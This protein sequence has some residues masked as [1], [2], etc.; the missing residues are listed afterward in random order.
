MSAPRKNTEVLVGLFLFVGFCFVG[1]MTVIFGT[2]GQ[3]MRHTYEVDVEFP[4][5]DGIIRNSDVMLSG[6]PIGRVAETPALVADSFH[7]RVKLKIR[8]DVK[9]PKAA[10]FTIASS[11]LLGDKYIHVSLPGEFDPRDVVRPGSTVAG[12]ATGG[13]IEELTNK[14]GDVMDELSAE[15]KEIN[16]V[17]TGLND[18]LLSTKNLT[19]LEETFANLKASTES[20]KTTSRDMDEVIKKAGE[21]VDSAKTVMMTAN[22]AAGDLRAAVGDVRKAALAATKTIDSAHELFTKAADGSGTLGTLINDRKMAE[23]LRSLIANL[24]HSGVLFYRD[25]APAAP[26]QPGR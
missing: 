15:L 18:K 20:L 16:S 2:K 10:S 23:D 8:E 3:Q 5:A 1:A 9:I 21:T 24:R 22:G 25:R 4:S 19:N 11:G 14:G 17:T 13:G 7:V 12:K 26:P 6:A